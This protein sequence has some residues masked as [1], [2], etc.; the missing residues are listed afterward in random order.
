MC[1]C[2]VYTCT[3]DRQASARRRATAG[4]NIHG[5]GTALRV[6]FARMVTHDTGGTGPIL[7]CP[8]SCRCASVRFAPHRGGEWEIQCV[9][10]V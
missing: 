7:L 4:G 6:G 10:L 3:E 8:L 9:E 5:L 1:T 2:E